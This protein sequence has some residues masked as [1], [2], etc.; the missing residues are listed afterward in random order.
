[1][2]VTTLLQFLLAKAVTLINR[3]SMAIESNEIFVMKVMSNRKYVSILCFIIF[4]IARIKALGIMSILRS[5]V[6]VYEFIV[7]LFQQ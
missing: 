4:P 5:A 3:T 1:M 7:F 6:P 2:L